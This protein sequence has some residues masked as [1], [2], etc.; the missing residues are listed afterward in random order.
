MAETWEVAVFFTAAVVYVI[1]ASYLY[2]RTSDEYKLRKKRKE[3]GYDVPS[4]MSSLKLCCV[5]CLGPINRQRWESKHKYYRTDDYG[6]PDAKW[7]E[8][9]PPTDKNQ[10]W[11]LLPRGDKDRHR[12]LASKA[13]AEVLLQVLE[14]EYNAALDKAIQ[15]WQSHMNPENWNQVKRRVTVQFSELDQDEIARQLKKEEEQESKWREEEEQSVA[16]V[17]STAA[18][19][20]AAGGQREITPYER[21]LKRRKDKQ[22]ARPAINL[23]VPVIDQQPRIRA[24]TGASTSGATTSSSSAATTRPLSTA[25]LRTFVTSMRDDSL[26]DEYLSLPLLLEK[27]SAYGPE[28]RFLNRDSRVV[29]TVK[30][31][32]RIDPP[33]GIEHRTDYINANLIR[34]FSGK[35]GRFIATQGPLSGHENQKAS[36]REHFWTMIWNYQVPVIVM[37]I[38]PS[39]HRCPPYWPTTSRSQVYT[40]GPFTVRHL[41]RETV[42]GIVRT[43]LSLR[44][45]GA[46]Q[47]HVVTHLLFQHWPATGVP[48][49]TSGIITLLRKMREAAEGPGP[50]VVHDDLGLGP[51][52]VLLGAYHLLRMVERTGKVDVPRV[53]SALRHDRGGLVQT[54]AEYQFLYKLAAVYSVSAAPKAAPPPAY[55]HAPK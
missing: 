17:G 24:N 25:E 11:Q 32:V 13:T 14:A 53:V 38:P 33:K 45:R 54:L 1:G 10:H 34:G 48:Q 18:A 16:A 47:E 41:N 23:N 7:M 27:P 22:A 31:R 35:K 50:I 39:A 4:I 43:V 26:Q 19:A 36:T 21:T 46:H 8:L 40:F 12:S 30:T 55:R 5:L 15:Q 49:G 37:M 28:K 51:T 44:C 20:A 42:G 6:P 52:G 3:L 29:P 2:W 9:R